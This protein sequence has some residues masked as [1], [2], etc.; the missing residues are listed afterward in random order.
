MKRLSTGVCVFSLLPY[1]LYYSDPKKYGLKMQLWLMRQRFVMYCRAL[2]VLTPSSSE[3]S[4]TS[5]TGAAKGVVLDRS[6][7]SDI[8]FA[9][10]V[11]SSP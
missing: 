11:N 8:V 4:S 10:K 7:M 3:A 2:R 1:Q 6:L 9:D 5:T